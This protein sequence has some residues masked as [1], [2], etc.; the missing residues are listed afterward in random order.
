MKRIWLATKF[1]KCAFWMRKHLSLTWKRTWVWATSERICALDL[2]SLEPSERATTVKTTIRKKDSS[3]R[4]KWQGSENLKGTRHFDSNVRYILV[5]CND[6]FLEPS[7]VQFN[8]ALIQSNCW[9]C[10]RQYTFRFARHM[11]E[12]FPGFVAD[13]PHR[14]LPPAPSVCIIFWMISIGCFK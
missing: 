12:L 3:G 11:V 8:Q 10:C 13:Q 14:L 9:V 2:G 1:F 6:L 4:V 7:K 5:Y